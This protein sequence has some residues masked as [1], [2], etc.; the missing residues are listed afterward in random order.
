MTWRRPLA[1]PT[2]AAGLPAARGHAV[3]II[4]V[5]SDARIDR[6]SHPS[7]RCTVVYGEVE[8]QRSTTAMTSA[9]TSSSG[10]S[11]LPWY[12]I[13]AHSPAKALASW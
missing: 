7:P 3:Y 8:D 6:H 9:S 11:S 1:A 10:T 2:A 4:D 13:S 12:N 5:V